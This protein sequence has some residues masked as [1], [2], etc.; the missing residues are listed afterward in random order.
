MQHGL[1]G[2]EAPDVLG[3]DGLEIDGVAIEALRQQSSDD[4]QHH[5]SRR[6][7]KSAH[8]IHVIVVAAQFLIHRPRADW[9]LR[10]GTLSA[11]HDEQMPKRRAVIGPVV[12][13]VSS[14]R[15]A[16]QVVVKKYGDRDFV[17]SG[18]RQ[19]PGAGPAREVRHLSDVAGNGVRS[20]P[21]LGQ[22]TLERSGMWPDGAGGEP[23]DLDDARV[24]SGI[25]GDLRKWDHQC[26][27]KPKLCP[28]RRV[29]IPPHAAMTL[30][31]R[32][33]RRAT[34]A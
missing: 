26:A 10:N 5:G 6:R 11:Q 9:R 24:L 27:P 23:I 29:T 2:K 15:A 34:C 8:V 31:P 33:Q 4:P 1:L 13:R 20:V 7:S 14:T 3:R 19:P 12:P 21:A 32:H 30:P 18:Q 16:R 17:D 25:H 28:V 22:A